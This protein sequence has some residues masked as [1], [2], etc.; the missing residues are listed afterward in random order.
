[1]P[2]YTV[3]ASNTG[4]NTA[5]SLSC[6]APSGIAS[7]NLLVIFIG[8]DEASN[9]TQFSINDTNYPGWTKAG[10]SGTSTVDAHFAIFFKE[11]AGTE[12][13]VTVD[14]ADTNEI[15]AFYYCVSL[16]DTSSVVTSFTTDTASSWVISPP[17]ISDGEWLLLGGM[18]L[19]GGDLGTPSVSGSGWTYGN[20][21]HSGTSSQDCSV[22]YA[23]ND[24]TGSTPADLTFTTG[25][26]DDGA[27]LGILA[28][29]SVTKISCAT[30]SYSSSGQS[31]E[32]YKASLLKGAKGSY[33]VS[34][35]TTDLDYT[36]RFIVDTGSYSITGEL[37]DWIE[38]WVFDIETG[39]YD[40]TGLTTDWI[41][42]WV[43][44]TEIGVYNVIGQSIKTNYSKPLNVDIG[45]YSVSGISADFINSLVIPLAIGEYNL[46]GI[47]ADWNRDFVLNV[48][49][50]SYDSTGYPMAVGRYFNVATGSYN[51]TGLEIDYS[52]VLKLATGNFT[53][54]GLNP[55]VMDLWTADAND[56][57]VD[58]PYYFADGSHYPQPTIEVETGNYSISGIDANLASIL[59]LNAEVGNYSITGQPIEFEAGTSLK[60]DTGAYNISGLSTELIRAERLEG[61]SGGFAV[62]GNNAKLIINHALALTT[63]TYSVSEI[64]ADLTRTLKVSTGSYNSVGV[65]SRLLTDKY[66][67]AETGYLDLVGFTSEF[68]ETYIH[69]VDAGNYSIE[70]IP[71]NFLNKEI[72]F[73][74]TG[75][76]TV[77][78]VAAQLNYTTHLDVDTESYIVSGQDI[79]FELTRKVLTST[80]LYTVSGQAPILK[81]ARDLSV[82]I[83][84]Y[85][86]TGKAAILEQ[87]TIESFETGSYLI[88]G[89]SIDFKEDRQLKLATGTYST[90]GIDPLVGENHLLSVNVGSYSITGLTSDFEQSDRHINLATGSYSI[91]GK[92]AETFVPVFCNPH[93]FKREAKVYIYYDDGSTTG[94]KLYQIDISEITFGQTFTEHSY[95]SKT[96]Q[97]QNMFEQSVINKANP[98]NFELTFPAIRESDLRILFDRALD[99]DT[100]DIYV[101][102][103]YDVF[104]IDTCVVTNARF[105]MERLKPLSMGITGEGVKLARVGTA[106]EYSLPTT[107]EARTGR[108][109]NRLSDL[110]ITL[111]TE[112]LDTRLASITVELQNEVKWIPYTTVHGALSV[113]ISGAQYPSNF[114]VE[115]RILAGTVTRYLT[116]DNS[117]LLTWGTNSALNITAGQDIGDTYGVY[118]FELDLTNCSFTNR[119]DTGEV[120]TQSYDWRLTQNPTNLSD[121]VTYT[122]A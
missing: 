40:I 81:P 1:M 7:G 60:T 67:V 51:L 32:L 39:I 119:L 56:F 79:I 91:T 106:G 61:A 5:T 121:I 75:S 21:S 13:A 55:I 113:G 57:T 41:E 74:D 36:K 105:I 18:A 108:T 101:E 35:Q 115:K 95:S 28:V 53:L 77:S 10:E 89:L 78:G 48:E 107:P 73:S 47:V 96:L 71:V 43:I 70:G 12:G 83:G 27:A 63:G 34:G 93:S 37:V 11:A 26:A 59:P 92:R 54:V 76:Y 86:A 118:G 29:K 100:F 80:G 42:D 16:V 44:D 112:T 22:A 84:S 62:Y 30:G 45:N 6:T 33:S 114:T 15:A 104:K 50:G 2:T 65:D 110:S 109:Y 82:D 85:I 38:D 58:T 23:Y 46:T 122:T 49:I 117:Q 116:E 25:D 102:T 97:E 68:T 31:G 20:V 52:K 64:T 19:D 69:S 120:F 17:S 103:A 90:T 72:L 87:T 9:T 99:C 14:A 94:D 111:G 88:T 4:G 66:I 24:Y 3:Q 98:A 8:N